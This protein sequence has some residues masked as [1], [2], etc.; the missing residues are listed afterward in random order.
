[1]KSPKKPKPIDVSKLPE[2]FLN[3]EPDPNAYQR[4][5]RVMTGLVAVPKAEAMADAPMLKA[6]ARKVTLKKRSA[7]SSTS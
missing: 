2:R 7:H 6:K 1:M 3:E 5:M 4:F